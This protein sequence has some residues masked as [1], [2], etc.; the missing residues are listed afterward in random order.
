MEGREFHVGPVAHDVLSPG[1]RLD[2]DLDSKTRV[3]DIMAPVLTPSL[4]SGLT[5]SFGGPEQPGILTQ[6]AAFEAGDSMGGHVGIPLKPE[7]PG[8]S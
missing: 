2:Y 6:P 5:G 1:L 3:L 4:L 8:P 7:A